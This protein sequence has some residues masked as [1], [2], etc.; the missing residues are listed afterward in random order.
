MSSGHQLQ[1]HKVKQITS[2]PW[3]ALLA[4]KFPSHE[5][6]GQYLQAPKSADLQSDR[7]LFNS[8]FSRTTR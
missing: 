3:H 5:V 1:E 7:H 4:V 6:K 8:L 2:C